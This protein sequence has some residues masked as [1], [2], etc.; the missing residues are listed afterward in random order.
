LW[1]AQLCA[2]T[3]PR[4]MIF[5]E[6]TLPN[7]E[8]IPREGVPVDVVPAAGHGMAVENP[9]GLAAAVARAVA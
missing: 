1:R 2:L 6:S 5:A 9:A 7:A 3:M 8:A 4:T